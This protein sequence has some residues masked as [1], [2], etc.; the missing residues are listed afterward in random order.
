MSLIDI[1]N[2]E[3]SKKRLKELKKVLQ[4]NPNYFKEA[5]ELKLERKLYLVNQDTWVCQLYF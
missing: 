1:F 5:E 2:P 4:L 3:R